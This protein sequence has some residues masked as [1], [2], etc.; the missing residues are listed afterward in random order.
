MRR[1]LVIYLLS[2]TGFCFVYSQEQKKSLDDYIKKGS[3]WI[4]VRLTKSYNGIYHGVYTPEESYKCVMNY[5][6]GDTLI[7]DVKYLKMNHRGWISSYSYD[8]EEI[9][10][11]WLIRTDSLNHLSFE[12]SYRMS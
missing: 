10:C 2:V 8:F 7:G 11:C 5:I 12:T 6:T 3:A 4:D 9:E 1:L